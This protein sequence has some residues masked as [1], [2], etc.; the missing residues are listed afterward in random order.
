M[1]FCVGGGEPRLIVGAFVA[2]VG[3]DGIGNLVT[4]SGV[5]VS[6]GINGG[7]VGSDVG[8]FVGNVI[9]VAHVTSLITPC[10]AMLAPGPARADILPWM[11]LSDP[12]WTD[13]EYVKALKL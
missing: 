10:G 12:T 7:V 5:G 11:Y 1:I 6:E 4:G 8:A 3:V 2:G 13:P 9:R